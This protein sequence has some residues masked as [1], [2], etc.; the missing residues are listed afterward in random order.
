MARSS[1]HI[2]TIT[3]LCM[4][5]VN[6]LTNARSP[7]TYMVGDK[8]GWNLV[9]S[10]DGWARDKT[11]YAGDI[12]VFRYDPKRYDMCIVNQTGYEMCTPNE[13]ATVLSSGEDKI[14]LAYGGNYF[15]GTRN[16]FDCFN[17]MKME[18][19]A[20]SPPHYLNN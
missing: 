9:G 8:N 6:S 10:G 17:G 20:L 18:V 1:I 5:L 3:M 14:S 7:T 15:I 2:I 19:N 4:F 11:F 16:P 13:G 12:L